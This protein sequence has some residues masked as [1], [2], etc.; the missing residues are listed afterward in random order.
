MLSKLV[1]LLF[2]TILYCGIAEAQ[3]GQQPA[4]LTLPLAS[5]AIIT[6]LVGNGTTMTATCNGPCGMPVGTS[7]F[8][9][10]NINPATCNGSGPNTVA[11]ASDNQVSWNSS[12]II[13]ASGQTGNFTQVNNPVL[14]LTNAGFPGN[15]VQL[16]LDYDSH[17]TE[18]MT[19]LHAQSSAFSSLVIRVKIRPRSPF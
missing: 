17:L 11:A 3:T 4:T 19:A 18:A 6:T 13:N 16:L 10:T 8:T 15:S 14:V 12:C 2:A 7:S 9:V 1:P 5:P